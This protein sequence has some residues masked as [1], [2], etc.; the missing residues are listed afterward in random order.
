MLV[1]LTVIC[2]FLFA[3]AELGFG[4]DQ[5]SYPN[6]ASCKADWTF[7]LPCTEVHDK[8]KAQIKAWKGPDNCGDGIK[9]NYKLT[10]SNG[11]AIRAKH[12]TPDLLFVD[13]MAFVLNESGGLCKLKGSSSRTAKSATLDNGANYCAM[14]NLVVGAK[15]H[16]AEGY[17]ESSGDTACTQYSV[18]NCEV[19]TPV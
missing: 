1:K 10:F 16:E 12:S 8:L 3:F 11:G 15:L 14:H 2:G 13:A 7:A 19:Y 5:T 4:A 9:C 18:A 17:T 6:H